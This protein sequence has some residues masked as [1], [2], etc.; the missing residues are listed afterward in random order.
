MVAHKFLAPPICLRANW[1]ADCRQPAEGGEAITHLISVISPGA[2]LHEASLLIEGKVPDINLA[3]GLEDG[4]RGPDH[5]ASV[6]ENGF[7]HRGNHILT[8]GT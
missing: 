8:I 7:G 5:F 2:E 4:R 1:L 6:V 3:A